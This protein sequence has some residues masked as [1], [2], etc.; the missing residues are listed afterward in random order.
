MFARD[1]DAIGIVVDWID[2]YKQ[3]RLDD[4]L[5]LYDDRA[6]ISCCEGGRFEGPTEIENYWRSRL[7]RSTD[8]NFEIDALMPD[9]EGVLLDYRG[10]DG[11]P[12]RTF[13]RFTPAG[14]IRLTA[15]EPI[16]EFV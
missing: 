11:A 2:A 12:V 15:C 10:H 1:F 7:A 9:A 14:K 6:T 5:E 3:R 13:F 16:A 8:Y 4:L